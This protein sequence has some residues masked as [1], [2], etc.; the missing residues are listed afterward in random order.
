MTHH[1]ADLEGSAHALVV[2]LLFALVLVV[3]AGCTSLADATFDATADALRGAER[4]RLASTF[5]GPRIA[6]TWSGMVA[7]LTTRNALIDGGGVPRLGPH[8]TRRDAGR[9]ATIQRHEY[10]GDALEVRWYR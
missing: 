10:V 8:F 1:D 5:D 2:M 4:N 7:S 3:L 6:P 9:V